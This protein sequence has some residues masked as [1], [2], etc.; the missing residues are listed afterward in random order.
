MRAKQKINIQSY[1]VSTPPPT[2]EATTGQDKGR[3]GQGGPQPAVAKS[4]RGKMNFKIIFHFPRFMA[5]NIHRGTEEEEEVETR[6]ECLPQKNI[7]AILSD[8]QS[9][10]AA[11][12]SA[13]WVA[14][15]Y[16]SS[17]LCAN[18]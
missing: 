12:S 2:I 4:T 15:H 18:Y 7:F 14:S 13:T 16:I 1:F 5:P 8:P 6:Y 11:S 17:T 9:T 3:L 10:A